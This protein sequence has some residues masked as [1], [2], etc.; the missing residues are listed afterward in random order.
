[1]ADQVTVEGRRVQVTYRTLFPPWS[2]TPP[3]T[4]PISGR[5]RRRSCWVGS[6]R[7]SRTPPPPTGPISPLTASPRWTPSP[8]SQNRSTPRKSGCAS[9]HPGQDGPVCGDAG[10][11]GITPR[12]AGKCKRLGRE[13]LPGLFSAG[14]TIPK[15]AYPARSAHRVWNRFRQGR[16]RHGGTARWAADR[17]RLVPASGGGK[18]AAEYP[19]APHWGP[20]GKTGNSDS[21]RAAASDPAGGLRQHL[22]SLLVAVKLLL[23]GRM[24]QVNAKLTGMLEQNIDGRPCSPLWGGP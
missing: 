21:G 4:A 7:R 2:G 16:E 22:L 24:A 10:P 13:P 6:R 20:A 15:D 11:A 8:P 12:K 9:L 23:P 18:A 3:I 17:H 1:M 5:Q 14:Q 19:G